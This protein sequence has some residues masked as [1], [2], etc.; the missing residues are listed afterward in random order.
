MERTRSVDKFVAVSG[1]GRVVPPR[2]SASSA[3]TSPSKRVGRLEE[4]E[5]AAILQFVP[6]TTGISPE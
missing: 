1:D 3:N 2:E 6:R 4:D 5:H